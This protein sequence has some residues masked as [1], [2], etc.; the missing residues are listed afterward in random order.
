MLARLAGPTDAPSLRL[1]T[2]GPRDQP[3]RLQTLRNTIAWSY[4]LLEPE[5]QALFRRLGDLRG[6]LHARGGGGRLCVQLGAGARLPLDD[7]LDGVD[8]LL[9]QE[10]AAASRRAR[11]ASRASRC[12]RRSASTGWRA[13]R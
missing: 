8:S 11:T 13:W 9:G 6:R 12:W 1:L 10:P 2:G 5:E 3:A 4:D 7:A